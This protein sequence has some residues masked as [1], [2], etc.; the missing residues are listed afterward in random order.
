MCQS[1]PSPPPAP[2]YTGAAVAQ[3]AANADVARLSAK[4]SNP[5][6]IGPLGT[7]TVSYGA[8]DI[9]TVT[10]T[11]TPD[12][13]A[14]LN[15]QQQVQ[16]G[17]ANLGLQGI[18]TVSGA[19]SAPFQSGSPNIQT[20]IGPT[21]TPNS[22]PSAGLYG[23]AGGP[24]TSNVAAMPVNAGTTGQQ[25]ILSRLEPTLQRE[26]D[27]L[28][29]QLRNQGLTAG[30]EAYD[31]AMRDQGLKE[32]D[33]LTQAALQGI[34]LDLSA[35]NQGFSQ[36]MQQAQQGNQ[37]IA[38][39]FGQGQAA[40]QAENA[41]QA[42]DINQRLQAA[43]FGNTASAQDLARA[44]A[45][46]NQ[47]LN[48]VTALMSGSQIQLPQFQGYTGQNVAPAPIFAG[49]QAQAQNA[50]QQYGIQQ[51]GVNANNAGLYGLAGSGLTAY[52]LSR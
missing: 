7:Q 37:A 45:L 48:E 12:A 4:L 41:A 34:N 43:Q 21:G 51:A 27:Q 3:G 44:L 35:N 19:M 8:D 29:T 30:G 22:G 1:S 9:P 31:N 24:D 26:R 36:A 42:Q 5:N 11:L 33:L 39:N 20:S 10:Q 47:P 50:M 25:A 2:D 15:S 16:K 38:Q 49:A 40:A 14:T 18:D 46:R 28:Q 52:G 13:Q 23:L 17:L 6:I 32:N